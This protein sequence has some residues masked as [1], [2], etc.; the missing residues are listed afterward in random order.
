MRTSCSNPFTG[1]KVAYAYPKVNV[2]SFTYVAVEHITRLRKYA[3]VIEVDV[4]SIDISMWTDDYVLF[5]HPVCYPFVERGHKFER[6]VRLARAKRFTL[7]GFEVSDT[8]RL[9]AK[10]VRILDEFDLIA[11]PSTWSKKAM[12]ESGLDERKVYV[13]PH[14]VNKRFLEVESITSPEIRTLLD[15]KK[16]FDVKFVLFNLW[17]SGFRKGADLVAKAMKI[18]QAKRPDIVLLLKT[19]EILDPYIPKLK[20]VK[21]VH[22]AKMLPYEQYAELYLVA[23]A[24]VVASRGGAFEIAGIEGIA[25][26]LPTLVPN[27]GCFTDYV[28]LA[29]PV[30]VT[31]ARPIVLPKNPIHI[32]RGYEIDVNDLANKIVEVF[33]HYEEYK[34]KAEK[35]KRKLVKRFD[36][37][38]IVDDFVRHLAR[39]L[40]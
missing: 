11:T 12:V 20:E 17:H 16:S 25:K 8:D 10:A 9:S 34:A 4:D 31:D 18:V 32:G 38:K 26:G 19:G 39:C 15:L 21:H 35:A 7:I 30:E 6:F 27:A 22:V 24:V 14:G 1:R 23:D 36:W 37:D 13:M 5:V 33:D 40:A 29:I 3:H 28:D 2:V